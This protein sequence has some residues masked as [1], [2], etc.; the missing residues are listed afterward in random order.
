MGCKRLKT[1]AS[2]VSWRRNGLELV[3]KG[4]SDGDSMDV[5]FG[6]DVL[7]ASYTLQCN[8]RSLIV[9]MG[10]SFARHWGGRIAASYFGMD[11]DIEGDFSKMNFDWDCSGVGLYLNWYY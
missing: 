1:G 6:V 5:D 10:Y 8:I 7:Y 3:G 2:G 11:L 9:N 4:N